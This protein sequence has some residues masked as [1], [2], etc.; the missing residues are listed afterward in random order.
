MR[1]GHARGQHGDDP[2]LDRFAGVVDLLHID[3]RRL[4][5]ER[6]TIGEGLHLAL[7]P[8]PSQDFANC[9]A[10]QAENLGKLPLPQRRPRPQFAFEQHL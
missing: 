8:E 10:R 6:P 1:R 4:R 9:A 7:L 2:A 3:D 5:H